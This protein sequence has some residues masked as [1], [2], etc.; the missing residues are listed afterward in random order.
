[1]RGNLALPPRI[2]GVKAVKAYYSPMRILTR[3]LPPLLAT[4]FAF[5]SSF[6]QQP[7]IQAAAL[8]SHEGMTISAK[9]WLDPSQYKQPF[10]KRS[11]LAAGI[12]AIQVSFRNDS[13]E[14]VKVGLEHIRLTLHIDQDNLQELEPLTADQVAEATL[15]PRGKDPTAHRRFPL[16]V[17]SGVKSVKDKDWTEMQQQAQNAAV[18]TRVVAAHSTVQGLLYFDMQGQLD[19]LHSAR[20]YIPDITIMGKNQ[21]LTYFEI[22]L[23][24]PAT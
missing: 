23:S 5:A 11:P 1:M 2:E 9:P 16:P 19:L 3:V 20:L 15:R 21:S 7:P 6:P 4:S 12:L 14:S 22:D 13:S 18:P 8:E 17:G 24:R 10:P